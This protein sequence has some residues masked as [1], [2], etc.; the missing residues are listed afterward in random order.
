MEPTGARS[1]VR[2]ASLVV[3][4]A[5]AV[6]RLLGF[7]RDVGLAILF[8]AGPVGDALLIALRLPNMARRVLGEGGLHTAFVP[9]MLG[10]QAR[11]GEQAAGQFAGQIV[12]FLVLLFGL[13]AVFVQVLALPL[14]LLL[15][16]PL[17]TAE[18]A[19]QALV[20]AFPMVAGSGLAA[21]ASAILSIQHR[22]ALAA[23]SGVMVNIVLVLALVWLK[24]HPLEP[25]VA[26]IWL[27]GLSGGSG[28]V[29]GI[30]L[31]LVVQTSPHSPR[32]TKPRWT[33]ALTRFI[34]LCGPGMVIAAGS[35]LAFLI[36]ISQSGQHSG[37]VSQLYFADR[38]TQL[39]FGFIAAI[40]AVVVLPAISRDA[41]AADQTAF[42]WGMDHAMLL[43]L[44]LALFEHGAFDH[45]AQQATHEA[46]AGF[47]LALPALAVGRVCAHGFFAHGRIKEPLLATLAG[48]ASVL[49]ICLL[50][51]HAGQQDARSF[52]LALSAGAGIEMLV[53]L[54]FL[55][56]RLGW[57]PERAMLRDLLLALVA[58][59][60]MLAGIMIISSI[61]DP[62][63]TDQ[64]SFGFDILSLMAKCL[65][66]CGIYGVC[67]LGFGLLG[68]PMKAQR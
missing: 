16:A 6:S 19:S 53:G 36:L 39:P 28:L 45:H 34:T 37:L 32:W 68:R 17:Q 66:G 22:F 11:E 10:Q 54:G 63:L 62:F 49:T 43:S 60:F 64:P 15:G 51:Q 42:R 12:M 4:A 38:V 48:L 1:S 58:T 61:I 25:D 47:A 59:I 20:L 3:G 52:A 67:A 2:P 21:V 40:L 24:I 41:Q 50:L 44:V 5:A 13:L 57:R 30:V 14:V 7:A 26:A 23:W 27:A 29:Q 33:P 9:M 31:M 35:Q 56:V 8:G 18:I 46:L 65:G 55:L